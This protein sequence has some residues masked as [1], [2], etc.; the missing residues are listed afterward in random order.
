MPTSPPVQ[1]FSN[2]SGLTKRETHSAAVRP[3]AEGVELTRYW[4]LASLPNYSTEEAELVLYEENLQQSRHA[5]MT[6]LESCTRCAR[7]QR[8][9]N[10][11]AINAKRTLA[12]VGRPW[13][14]RFGKATVGDLD[15][16]ELP[17]PQPT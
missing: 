12:I 15:E 17:R 13:M 16:R 10:R 1:T 7:S 4:R 9:R 3:C 5:L 11:L 14:R 8:M 6:H 2:Q